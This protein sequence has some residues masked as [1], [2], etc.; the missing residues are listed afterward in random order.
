MV[1]RGHGS[2]MLETLPDLARASLLLAGPDFV[3]FYCYSKT[4]IVSI[5]SALQSSGS[6]SSE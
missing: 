3:S 4:T 2:F 6:H 5:A 1:G